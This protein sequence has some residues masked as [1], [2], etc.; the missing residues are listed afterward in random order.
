M[1]PDLVALDG[2]S[3]G[4]FFAE[5]D[6]MLQQRTGGWTKEQRVVVLPEQPGAS[7][8][9]QV[10]NGGLYAVVVGVPQGVGVRI[11]ACPFDS[12]LVRE[13]AE[14]ELRCAKGDDTWNL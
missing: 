6:P 3:D 12:R 8:G 13:C 10:A 7:L 11:I 1:T 5:A 2:G 9:R 14:G 4:V